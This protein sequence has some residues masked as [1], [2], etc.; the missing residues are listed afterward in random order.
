MKNLMLTASL[1]SLNT[2]AMQANNKLTTKPSGINPSTTQAAATP[3][4]VTE[5]I[6]AVQT[7]ISMSQSH[8]GG[9]TIQ[10]INTNQPICISI[11]DLSEKY[12][13]EKTITGNS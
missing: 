7:T 11:A 9:G 8:N 6:A 1:L 2:L 5:T 10:V 12:V 3:A 13:F 4:K